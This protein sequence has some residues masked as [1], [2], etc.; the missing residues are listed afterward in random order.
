[1]ILRDPN[2]TE[3]VRECAA[4]FNGYEHFGS[5][6]ACADEAKARKRDTLIAL[7][8]ELF[9]AYRAANHQGNSDYVELYREL[10]PLFEQAPKDG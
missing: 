6:A 9:F 8:N 3:A 2:D 5:F 1:L 4:S 10:L 7:R